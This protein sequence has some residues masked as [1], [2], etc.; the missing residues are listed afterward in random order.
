MC[1]ICMYKV[2]T[3]FGQNGI[4]DVASRVFTKM[5]QKDWQNEG[6]MDSSITIDWLIDWLI[7]GVLMPLSTIFQLYHGDQF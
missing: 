5:L 7:F 4:K 2:W 1:S 6:Q 3:K